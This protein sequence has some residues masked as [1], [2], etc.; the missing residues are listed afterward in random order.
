MNLHLT[1]IKYFGQIND[2]KNI[3]KSFDFITDYF[4]TNSLNKKDDVDLALFFNHWSMYNMTVN[5]LLNQFERKKLNENG[6]FILAETMNFT[7]L[8]DGSDTY[9]EVNKQAIQSNKIRWCEWINHDFQVKRNVQI[10][11]MY[12]ESC[13]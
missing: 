10:K 11:R 13:K 12:C 4:K 3:S 5:H 9:I 6:L 1:F 8:S 7:N 2:S